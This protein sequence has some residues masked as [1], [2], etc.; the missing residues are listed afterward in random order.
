MYKYFVKRNLLKSFK[1]INEGNYDFI[2][3]QFKDQGVVH[4]F[5]GENHPLAGTRT[6]K[7]SIIFWY[8]RLHRLM[9]DLN[10]VINK[11]AISGTPRKTIAMLEWTD[12]L[13][14]PSGKMYSNE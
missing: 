10:F 8:E 5:S 14:D 4:W 9:P 1:A 3:K 6:S 11:I 13:T 2:T 7:K 12:T